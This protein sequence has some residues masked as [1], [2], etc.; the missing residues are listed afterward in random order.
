M[1]IPSAG[2][3]S[4]PG[5]VARGVVAVALVLALG[6]LVWVVAQAGDADQ[7]APPGGALA[8]GT[9]FGFVSAF[10]S[11]RLTFEPAEFISGRDAQIAAVEDGEL[12]P[13][14]ELHSDFYVRRL[15]SPVELGVAPAFE[16]E[17]LDNIA[18]THREVT[19]DEMVDL[20]AGTGDAGWVYGWLEDLPVHLTLEDGEVVRAVEWYLP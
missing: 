4:R 8:D 14:Q 5:R 1:G 11:T 17:L 9:H 10:T 18:I 6:L 15:N 19:R 3:S 7:T 12:A 2:V 20:F 16:G 13:G